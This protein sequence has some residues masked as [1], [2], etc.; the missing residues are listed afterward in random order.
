MPKPDIDEVLL[1]VEE[2]RRIAMDRLVEL[3]RWIEK[4]REHASLP[5]STL[6]ELETDFQV[7]AQLA[8][9]TAEQLLRVLRES[10]LLR[11]AARIQQFRQPDEVGEQRGHHRSD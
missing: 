4:A 11:D 5:S 2:A 1:E 10:G 9:V 6:Y 3:T 7:I 8:D